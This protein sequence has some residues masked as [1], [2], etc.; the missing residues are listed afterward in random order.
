[1]SDVKKFGTSAVYFTALLTIV[2]AIVLLRFGYAVGSVGLWGTFILI[3]IGHLVTIPTALAISELATN[4]RVE[5]GGEY[6][7]ISRSFGLNI[8]A[9]LG[10]LL[11]L[12]QTISVAFYIVAFT[13]AFDFLFNYLYVNFDFVLPKQVISIPAMILL[14]VLV[15][16][17]GANMGLKV[18]Y[19]AGTLVLIALLMFFFGK[20]VNGAGIDYFSANVSLKNSGNMFLVLAIIFPAFTGITA[21]VGLSGDLKNPG[22]SIPIG[23][24]A[25]TFTGL[26]LY[27]LICLKFANSALPKDLVENQLIMANIAIGGKILIPLGLAACTFTSALSS[28]MVGPRTL[29]ALALDNSLPIKSTN[30][31]LRQTRKEDNEPINASLVTCVIALVFVAFG[32]VDSVAQIISMFFLVTYGSL[33]LISFLHH[34]GS[35]PAY[36]PTFKSKW[37]ISLAGFVISVWA[38]FQISV[39]YTLIAY[40]AI[41]G[42]Y[43]YIE[44]YHSDRKGFS[45]IFANTLFQ[46]NRGLQ[47]YLQNKRKRSSS[48]QA[49]SEDEWRPSAICISRNT[50]KRDS[51][52][53]LLNWISYKYGF[54]TYLHLIDGYY[55][56]KTTEQAKIELDRLLSNL[57]TS[58]QV[59]IDTLISPSTTS[60]IAQSIQTPGIAGMENNMVIFEY[61]KSEPENDL[62]DI[63]TNF[64]MVNAGGF[65]VCILGTS[66]KPILYKNGIHIWVSRFDTEST[67]LMILLGFIIMG[68][69]SWKKANIKIFNICYAHE[70]DEIKQNMYEL[71]NSGRMPITETNIEIIER[72]EHV[73]VKEIINKRSIDAGLTMIGFNENT[74]KVEGDFSF[75]EGFENIGNVLFVHSNGEK[76]IN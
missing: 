13:E 11:Y 25:A 74:F 57:D 40:I 17:K 39:L 48:D 30:K 38:M 71:I 73:S 46:M 76:T 35:S 45:A 52:L 72:D 14:S 42:L 15:L 34:F 7:I 19:I 68:H 60:A 10:M 23:T 37:Y 12:S 69:P 29:Q 36:R 3:A 66:R 67:N 49:A 24:V 20:P 31:W 16:K 32:S 9:T 41:I 27:L 64:R 58:N 70:I 47:I 44:R 61:M 6:F 22:K 59:Y 75:F 43:I 5:G 1:M 2:G 8:G 21:G 54:G 4:K 26:I 33:C 50:F 55:S 28:I 51:A 56:K 63:M 53:K 65:D 18:L 62:N